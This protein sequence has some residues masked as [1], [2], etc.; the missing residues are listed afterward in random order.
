MKR[1]EFRPKRRFRTMKEL[2]SKYKIQ[3]MNG[4]PIDPNAQ[5]FVLRL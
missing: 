3:K 4:K 1:G 5:Y 2:Y